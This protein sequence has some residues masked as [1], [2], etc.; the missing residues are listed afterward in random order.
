MENKINND[1]LKDSIES[2]KDEDSKFKVALEIANGDVEVAKKL[3]SCEIK[4]IAIIKGNFIEKG[5]Q[6]YGLYIFY[7][8]LKNRLVDR[9][10]T[11]IA[12]NAS[13]ASVS[14]FLNWQE[15]ESKL[16]ELEWSG[17]NMSAQSTELKKN[18]NSYLNYE[19]MD[20]FEAAIKSNEEAKL[21]D[22]MF[23]I[24]SKSLQINT[25]QNEVSLELINKY[26]LQVAGTKITKDEEENTLKEDETKQEQLEEEKEKLIKDNETILDGAVEISPIRGIN[27][28]KIVPGQKILVKLDDGS[29]KQ[30][31]YIDMLGVRSGKKILPIVVTARGMMYDES[32]GYFLIAEINEGLV[33]R[34]IEQTP[35]NVKTPEIYEKEKKSK[36]L[37]NIAII[38]GA[39]VI[40]LF[41]LYIYLF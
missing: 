16:I 39:L 24:I 30:Q 20:K 27:L 37:R 17:N 12:F 13:Y 8:D 7:I 35:V 38:L 25:F 40:V 33:V 41:L 36:I 6:M 26:I 9:I 34:C 21:K 28:T 10:F 29:P 3:V 14:P 31:H 2:F 11:S 22:L 15:F 5:L 19:Y 32:F 4:D 23:E 1:V 18:I